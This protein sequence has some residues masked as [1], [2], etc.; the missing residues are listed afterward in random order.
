LSIFGGTVTEALVSSSR[1]SLP[2]HRLIG[3]V[4]WRTGALPY[5][6]DLEA[7]KGRHTAEY[8]FERVR[9]R[10]PRQVRI[11]GGKVKARA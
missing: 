10:K 3:I 5:R 4:D 7:G 8:L 6:F 11:S 2:G 9:V 1:S